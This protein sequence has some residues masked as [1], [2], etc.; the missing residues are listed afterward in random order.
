MRLEQRQRLVD[1]V[2]L[3]RLHLIHLARLD[4]LDDP[5][6]VEVHAEAD[7]AAMLGQMF[8]GQPQ[9]ARAGGADHEPVAPFGK[10]SS[11]SVSLNIS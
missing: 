9:A 4:E 2:A 11:G 7:A 6:R 3:V 5:A 10:C 1:D 8:D